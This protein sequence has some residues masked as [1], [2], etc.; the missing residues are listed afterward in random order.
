MP[1]GLEDLEESIDLARSLV[2]TTPPGRPGLPAHQVLLG[3]TLTARYERTGLPGDIDEAITVLHEAVRATSSSD[4]L[5]ADAQGHLGVALWA[6][7][8]HAGV[9]AD[10]EQAINHLT[11]A[12]Q[13]TDENSPVYPKYL[14]NLGTATLTSAERLAFPRKLIQHG[15]ADGHV[16]QELVLK[17]LDGAIGALREAFRRAR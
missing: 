14:A 15:R 8:K 16:Q 10:I 13:L 17:G 2:R 11:M 9:L 1:D 4:F 7:F 3:A 6:R 12:V 5:H